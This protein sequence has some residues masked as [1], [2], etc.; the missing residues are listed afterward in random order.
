M[1]LSRGE[2]ARA[3]RNV[4]ARGVAC[5]KSHAQHV[6]PH[7]RRFFTNSARLSKQ[8][9]RARDQEQ[10]QR[11][12]ETRRQAS[13]RA[14]PAGARTL[15]GFPARHCSRHS[16]NAA[17]DRFEFNPFAHGQSATLRIDALKT[18]PNIWI[19]WCSWLSR[20]SNT[21]EVRGS[22]AAK[23]HS[24]QSAVPIKNRKSLSSTARRSQQA[25]HAGHK[26]Q[27][28]AQPSRKLLEMKRKTGGLFENPERSEHFQGTSRL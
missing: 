12:S 24:S 10:L 28:R 8:D 22:I 18:C 6:V 2:L 14:T 20:Q 4:S 3:E 1:L 13:K 7:A 16:A 25:R 15:H 21:L 23:Q 17:I 5:G 19:P 26:H 9:Q 27:S 11:R